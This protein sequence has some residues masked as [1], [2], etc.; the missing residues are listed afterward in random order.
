MKSSIIT[1]GVLSVLAASGSAFAAVTPYAVSSSGTSTTL[2]GSGDRRLETLAFSGSGSVM[3]NADFVRFSGG[4][5]EGNAGPF[6]WNA[7]IDR[8]MDTSGHAFEA[9]PDRADLSTPLTG[10]ANSEG[11]ISEVFGSPLGYKNLSW[12]I[13][14]EGFGPYTLD[15]Y[16]NNVSAFTPDANDASVELAV[17][18]RGGNSDF[19]IQGIIGF[20]NSGPI[21]TPAY[22]VLRSQTGYAGWTLNTLEIGDNQNVNG[23]GLSLPQEW[24]QLLGVRISAVESDSGPD[25]VAVGMVPSPGAVTLAGAAG[26]LAFGRR[27]K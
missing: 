6:G 5:L 16:L 3:T 18:E 25:I 11:A 27:R 22:H 12:I 8:D 26:L 21:L 9:N 2:F 13:D 15:L 24:G 4:R 20:G 7:A 17:L 19:S 14:G 1:V 10:E 23:I